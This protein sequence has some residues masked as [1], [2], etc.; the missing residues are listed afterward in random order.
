MFIFATLAMVVG[1]STISAHAAIVTTGDVNPANP[2]TWTGS[3]PVTIANTADGSVTVNGGSTSTTGRVTMA[4]TFGV[5]GTLTVDGLGSTWNVGGIT[6]G[7]SSL[8]A[9]FAGGTGIVNI[10]NGGTI[11]S[12]G[13]SRVFIG[14]AFNTTGYLNITNGGRLTG[15]TTLADY[16]NSTGIMTVDGVGSSV[17][18]GSISVGE[19]GNGLLKILNG[20]TVSSGSSAGVARYD[21]STS[22]AIVDGL[23]SS[24]TMRQ[25]LVGTGMANGGSGAVGLLTVSN[26]ATLSNQGPAQL[27]T[28]SN[29]VGTIMVNGASSSWTN[30]PGPSNCAGFSAPVCGLNVGIEGTG[31]VSISDGATLTTNALYINNQSRLTVDLGTGSTVTVGGGTGILT[32]DGTIRMAAKATAASGTYT[33]I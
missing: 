12:G 6:A 25:L 18:G 8:P 23:G 29:A 13:T 2:A 32:N 4:T 27:G 15:G 17:S 7:T 3:T 1:L 26:G 5:T 28:L 24:W 9:N 21:T 20:A 11:N 14:A 30:I 16:L 19:R 22:R 10:T 31:H 33:P